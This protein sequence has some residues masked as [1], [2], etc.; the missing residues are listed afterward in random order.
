MGTQVENLRTEQ[1]SDRASSQQVFLCKKAALPALI[2]SK[3]ISV[4]CMK[5]V[6]SIQ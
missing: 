3:N 1:G 5:V 2:V 6:F 4:Y